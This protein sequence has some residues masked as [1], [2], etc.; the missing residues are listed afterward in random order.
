MNAST[1]RRENLLLRI[2]NKAKSRENAPRSINDD[3]QDQLM[4]KC[5]ICC[6]NHSSILSKV[7]KQVGEILISV[8]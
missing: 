8:S 7:E 6:K 1:S 2:Y 5:C 3:T 4:N